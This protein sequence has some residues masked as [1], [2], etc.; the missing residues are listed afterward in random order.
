VLE[1]S[2]KSLHNGD[3]VTIYGASRTDQG[4]HALGQVFH[5]DTSLEIPIERFA[6]AINTYLPQDIFVTSAR[7]VDPTFHARKSAVKKTYVYQMMWPDYMP[8]LRTTHGHVKGT[9]DFEAMHQAATALL[10]TQDFRSFTQNATYDSYER[11]VMDATLQRTEYGFSLT[12]TGTG[13][14]R[15]MVRIIMGTLLAI[16]QGSPISMR[17]V[18]AAQDRQVAGLNVAPEGLYLQQ[19][20]YE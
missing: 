10:G 8:H 1:D 9:L 2:L 12:I 18:L 19:V 3:D 17:E 13:F 20:D 5:F 14:L 7:R 11:T 4:V 6:L 16:G 15:H